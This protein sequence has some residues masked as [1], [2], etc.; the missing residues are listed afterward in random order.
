MGP[1]WVAALQTAAP[2]LAVGGAAANY[3]GE[4]KAARDRRSILNRSMAETEK[5]QDKAQDA[6]QTEAKTY[7]PAARQQ[8]MEAQQQATY[9]QSLK[10]V[11]AGGS[12][13]PTAGEGNVSEDFLKAKAD[14]A[15]SEGNRLTSVAREIAK[16]RA[17]GQQLTTEGLR[18]ADVTGR[19]GSMWSGARSQ[20][21]AA[22]LTAQNVD[23]PWYG[24]LGKLAQAI[25][26]GVMLGSPTTS[27]AGS[28]G[29][30]GAQLGEMGS[31]PSFWKTG[32]SR[33]KFG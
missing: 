14:R 13:I 1:E 7:D 5:T 19:V 18:R 28:Y 2:Y 15:L 33:I 3:L 22:Q 25:G 12:L 11:G 29:L 10:D 9:E 8:A 4:E 26:S 32:A 20:A 21:N 6:I 24:H 23:S 17:P 30:G 31:Q 16:A 27:A